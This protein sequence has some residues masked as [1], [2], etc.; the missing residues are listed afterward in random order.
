MKKKIIA[1]VSCIV[2]FVVF[3]VTL[4]VD[5][6]KSVER[7]Y[8]IDFT[9][10]LVDST[11]E[12]KT[13]SDLTNKSKMDVKFKS[14]SNL[15]SSVVSTASTI[16]NT[17]TLNPNSDKSGYTKGFKLEENVESISITVSGSW[18]LQLE[19][20]M[21][22]SNTKASIISANDETYTAKSSTSLK[23]ESNSGA[24]GTIEISSYMNTSILFGALLTVEEED[25][26]LY[27]AETYAQIGDKK[28]EATDTTSENHIIFIRFI[29]IVKDVKSVD[30]L[31]NVKYEIS[32][33][34]ASSSKDVTNKIHIVDEIRIN[35]SAMTSNIEDRSYT[36]NNHESEK[37]IM[38]T[39]AYKDNS[40]AYYGTYSVTLTVNGKTLST[41][42]FTVN[43]AT[44]A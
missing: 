41:K 31:K 38:Y 14:T 22:N 8:W 12:T 15:S 6:K 3:G 44:K 42:S 16:D 43:E 19:F 23:I 7:S 17:S 39:I 5:A 1:I 18:T 9:G 20:A 25:T 4:S 33:S 34:G 10:D 28:V 32:Y 24:S 21:M 30:D 37:Y 26:D 27:P 13:V 29:T 35:G 40:H 36:F 2:A 11:T